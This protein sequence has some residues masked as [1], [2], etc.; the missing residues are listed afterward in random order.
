MKK[1]NKKT[2]LCNEPRALVATWA[3][4]VHFETDLCLP[5]A[6]RGAGSEVK[7]E[8]GIFLGEPCTHE[9]IASFL[10]GDTSNPHLQIHAAHR[11]RRR[12]FLQDARNGVERG[13]GSVVKPSEFKH[14]HA[15]ARRRRLLI[16]LLLP[17]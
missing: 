6:Y 5:A 3:F 12:A 17:L 16:K 4:V 9:T 1:T 15:R 13:G 14:T 2:T 8:G 11:L 7:G 10:K